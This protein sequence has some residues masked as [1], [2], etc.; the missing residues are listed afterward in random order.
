VLDIRQHPETG[1]GLFFPSQTAAA[2]VEAVEEFEQLQG[3]FQPEMARLHAEK[4]APE[5]FEQRYLAFVEK[6][7]QE[8]QSGD[9]SKSGT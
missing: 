3:K 6:C 9:F 2:I 5:V 7:Y 4:F 8:F 1:T